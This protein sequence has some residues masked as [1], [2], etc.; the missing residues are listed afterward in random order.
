MSDPFDNLLKK[1]RDSKAYWKEAADI[2]EGEYRILRAENTA[3]TKRVEELEAEVTRLKL[4]WR[5]THDP[6]LPVA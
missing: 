6:S 1:T 5:G 3:L 4:Y 2:W